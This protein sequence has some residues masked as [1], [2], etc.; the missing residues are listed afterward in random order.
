MPLNR[1]KC[2][3]WH[4]IV[5]EF[6]NNDTLARNCHTMSQE[7]NQDSAFERLLDKGLQHIET[8]WEYYSLSATEKISGAAEALAGMLIVIVFAMMILFFFSIGFAV[9]LGDYLDNRAGG[10]ALA[11]LI[12]VPIGIGAYYVIPPI[13]RSR[14]IHNMLNDE[15]TDDPNPRG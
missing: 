12:F 2:F 14:I 1:E 5:K 13:V 6:K 4:S 8:R 10:F 15:N 3:L 11:G 9:W 7:P